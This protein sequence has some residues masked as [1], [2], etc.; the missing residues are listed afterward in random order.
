MGEA[1][2]LPGTFGGFEMVE[3]TMED[4]IV[5]QFLAV[6]MFMR[7]DLLSRCFVKIPTGK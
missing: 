4:T 2:C 3:V 6:A 7:G 1:G 5:S